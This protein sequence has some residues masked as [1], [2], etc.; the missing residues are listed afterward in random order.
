MPLGREDNSDLVFQTEDGKW[1]VV[2]EDIADLHDTH[3]PVLIGT[4]SVEDS[5]YLSDRLRKRGVPHQV[6]NAKHHEHEASIVAQAGR[7][8]AVTVSTNMAGRGTDIVLGGSDIARAGWQEEHDRVIELGGLFV[9][10]TEHHDARR[11]DNQL[12]GRAGRQGDPGCSQFYV[13][14]AVSYTHL[15]LPTNREV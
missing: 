3:Q 2:V 14:L 6:L 11:I 9:L 15:T 13:S 4:T 12:R 8:D 5:E 1:N 10:G 7:L